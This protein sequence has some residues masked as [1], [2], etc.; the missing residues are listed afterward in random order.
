MIK[1]WKNQKKIGNAMSNNVF[2]LI[3]QK[4]ILEEYIRRTPEVNF[5]TEF[6]KGEI[7]QL[8]KEIKGVTKN[9]KSKKIGK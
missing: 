6:V 8:E 7:D 9:E 1:F 5:F 3:Q 2:E 4:Y